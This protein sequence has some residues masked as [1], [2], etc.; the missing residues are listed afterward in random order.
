MS[1]FVDILS[2]VFEKPQNWIRTKEKNEQS[3]YDLIN[4]LLG[5]SGEVKGVTLAR[6]ILNYY[7]SFS[8]EDSAS[9]LFDALQ[10][11]HSR[12]ADILIADTAGRLQNKS[13][14]MDELEKVV[15]VMQK[16]DPQA[17]HETLL[18]LDSL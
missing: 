3:V 1:K 9:V 5:A 12:G 15:R 16:I 11:A 18:V 6:E 14:L 4:D 2:A 8:P 10:A 13:H 7:S 17:P